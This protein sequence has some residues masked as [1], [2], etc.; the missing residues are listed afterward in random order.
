MSI[1]S[2]R[3][4]RLSSALLARALEDVESSVDGARHECVMEQKPAENDTSSWR[5]GLS[6]L[7]R[8]PSTRLW[9]LTATLT[10][11]VLALACGVVYHKQ[12]TTL[13][14]QV[15]NPLGPFTKFQ[16][17][18][19]HGILLTQACM[20]H[21]NAGLVRIREFVWMT[22]VVRERDVDTQIDGGTRR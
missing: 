12:G 9:L 17:Y 10:T 6:Q 7:L 20:A 3:R 2:G 18:R 13:A 19:L 22:L 15:S 21:R 16:P 8:R 4:A 5:G 14:G 1:P 11:A